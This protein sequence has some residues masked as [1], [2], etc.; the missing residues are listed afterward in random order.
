MHN[1]TQIFIKNTTEEIVL[2]FSLATEQ[3]SPS[4]YCGMTS[5][6]LVTLRRKWIEKVLKVNIK[7]G[8]K[9][10]GVSV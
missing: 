6:W 2:A 8:I 9:P 5:A 10:I 1:S 3:L 4:G 7:S